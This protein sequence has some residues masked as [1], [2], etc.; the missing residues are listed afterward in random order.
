VRSI[1]ICEA[2]RIKGVLPRRLCVLIHVPILILREGYLLDIPHLDAFKFTAD[3][4][5]DLLEG[6]WISGFFVEIMSAFIRDS[7]A[8]SRVLIGYSGWTGY[9][10]ALASREADSRRPAT[11]NR[12]K[13][14]IELLQFALRDRNV[15]KNHPDLYDWRRLVPGRPSCRMKA[16]CVCGVWCGGPCS[17]KVRMMC[18]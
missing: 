2:I 12:A 18:W 14:L 3:K 7:V 13:E 11:T 5:G 9:S 4:L 15:D 1:D 8:P 10:L 16:R 6:N 17:Q